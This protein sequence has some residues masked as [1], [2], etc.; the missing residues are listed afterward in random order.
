MNR[1]ER[2]S[3]EFPDDVLNALSHYDSISTE[4]GNR[5]RDQ[6]ESTI[7]EIRA[8]PESFGYTERPTRGAMLGRFPYVVVFRVS[9][10]LLLFGGCFH[11]ASEPSRWRRRMESS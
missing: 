4:L 6:L 8:R 9:E 3:P 2:F 7:E 5:F 11:A 1:D 10:Q